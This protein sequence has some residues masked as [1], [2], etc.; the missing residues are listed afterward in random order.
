MTKYIFISTLIHVL[1]LSS[2]FINISEEQV[3]INN[4]T[5]DNKVANV[6]IIE[7]NENEGNN[8]PTPE[9]FY[10]G[11]GIDS[12]IQFQNIIPYGLIPTVI[13]NSVKKGY[14][15]Y[16]SNLQV[17]D[18]IILV[19]GKIIS[20]VNDIRGDAPKKLILTIIRNNYTIKIAVNRVKVY[21]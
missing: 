21:Y 16:D 19:N 2:L 15:A 1:V 5:N 10:W 4:N 8:T 12:S 20:G 14:S 3:V 9:N 11:I 7:I 18:K 13:V 17:D 6:Q